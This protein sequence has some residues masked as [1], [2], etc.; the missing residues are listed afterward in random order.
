MFTFAKVEILQ[1]H[2]PIGDVDEMLLLETELKKALK[3]AY[4]WRFL[5][6]H[7]DETKKHNSEC[8]QFSTGCFFQ[9]RGGPWP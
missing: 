5:E 3:A 4:D 2:V 9:K 6:H 8:F 7:G 1:F